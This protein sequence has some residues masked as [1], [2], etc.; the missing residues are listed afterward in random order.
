MVVDIKTLFTLGK[1]KTKT[2]YSAKLK[3]PGKLDLK[4]IAASFDVVLETPVVL[5]VKVDGLEIV[6]QG[7]GELLFKTGED[8]EQMEKIACRIYAAGLLSSSKSGP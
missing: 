7:Y 4:R 8:V 6:V 2:T 1:C 5:V 3:K